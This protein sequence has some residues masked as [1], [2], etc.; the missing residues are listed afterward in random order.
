M[1]NDRFIENLIPAL[2][3]FEVVPEMPKID[4][5]LPVSYK[6]GSKEVNK[7]NVKIKENHKRTG[8]LKSL[9]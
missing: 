8:I 6:N 9:Y 2:I 1:V 4:G 5:T 3:R 7:A